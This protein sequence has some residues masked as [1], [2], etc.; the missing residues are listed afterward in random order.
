MTTSTTT[1]T[2]TDTTDED[3][4]T[5][6]DVAVQILNG[7]PG[8]EDVERVR[9]HEDVRVTAVTGESLVFDFE[10]ETDDEGAESITGWT[11]TRRDAEGLDYTTDGDEIADAAEIDSKV[12]ARIRD[13][14]EQQAAD[15]AEA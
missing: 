2:L 11:F 10:R 7:L 5:A 8:V 6:W 9:G 4:T 12:V 3:M 13:W 15:V 1:W 14:A